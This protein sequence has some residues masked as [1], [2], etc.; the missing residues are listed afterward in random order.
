MLI[1]YDNL[2]APCFV[3]D[4]ERFRKNLSLIRHVADKSGAEIILAFKG[5]A[6]WGVF[7]ILRE[8]IGGAAASSVSEARLCFDEIGSKA[9][10]YSPVYKEEEFSQILKYSSHVSFKSLAQ[11]RKFDNTLKSLKGKISA[12]LLTPS[13]NIAIGMIN[14]AR[15]ICAL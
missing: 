15:M 11:Y 3:I 14:P 4:E 5:F 13:G 9:H 8:Y 6:M 10:T 12:T 2:P 1:T 7:D